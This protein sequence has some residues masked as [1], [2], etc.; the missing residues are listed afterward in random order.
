VDPPRGH[1]TKTSLVVGLK[2][3]DASAF[4]F[5]IRIESNSGVGSYS[6]EMD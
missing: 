4:D 1:I 2:G 6:R 3:L 5:G